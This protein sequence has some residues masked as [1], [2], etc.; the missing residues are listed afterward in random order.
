MEVLI[1]DTWQVQPG[2]RLGFD[3]NAAHGYRNLSHQIVCFHN[4]IHYPHN[5]D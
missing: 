5:L 1:K 4:I 2:E 3:A